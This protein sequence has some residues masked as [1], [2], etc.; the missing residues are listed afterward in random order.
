MALR[1]GK[2]SED[3][4]EAT[5]RAAIFLSKVAPGSAFGTTEFPAEL[6]EASIFSMAA[7]GSLGGEGSVDCMLV[8]PLLGVQGSF[9]TTPNFPFFL[10]GATLSPK[11][12][13]RD[14][15]I[16]VVASITSCSVVSLRLEAGSRGE[17]NLFI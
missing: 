7:R 17:F 15:T 2:L 5:P 13:P 16:F 4:V 14:L 8:S 1:L 6:R 9:V 10:C 3:D 12:K 11:T